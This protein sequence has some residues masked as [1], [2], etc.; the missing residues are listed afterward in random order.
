MI[1]FLNSQN[2]DRKITFLFRYISESD[3]KKLDK[4]LREKIEA[5]TP[6]YTNRKWYLVHY[7]Q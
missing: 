7:L 1:Y 6:V 3:E 2:Y 5:G 4:I